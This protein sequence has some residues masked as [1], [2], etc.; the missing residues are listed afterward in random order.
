MRMT[1]T[2]DDD[3]LARV[4]QI[5]ARGNRS[6]NSV[7]EE[8]VREALLRRAEQMSLRVVLPASGDPTAK[9]LVDILDSEALAVVSEDDGL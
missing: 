4:T 6:V 7:I 8:A 5:A 2:I 9:P 1:I 3:L